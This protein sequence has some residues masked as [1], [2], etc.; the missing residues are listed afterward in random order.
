MRILPNCLCL[1][2][3]LAEGAMGEALSPSTLDKLSSWQNAENTFEIFAG[4]ASVAH[5]LSGPDG[6]PIR[7]QKVAVVV[8]GLYNSPVHM[9]ALSEYFKSQNMSVLSVRLRGHYDRDRTYL[10]QTVQWTEWQAQI[11]EVVSLAADL[12]DQLIFVGHSTGALL[13]TWMAVENPRSIVGLALFAPAFGVHPVS[14]STARLLEQLGLSLPLGRDRI[15]TAHAA[16]QVE[17]MAGIF[18]DHIWANAPRALRDVPVWIAN[19]EVDVVIRRDLAEKFLRDLT[20][21]SCARTLIQI[22][23]RE[24]ILH[25]RIVSPRSRAWSRLIDSL[26]KTIL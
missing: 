3:F 11:R 21:G 12:G 1:A 10:S 26:A 9:N 13:L 24:M 7:S 14:R 8:S 16:K 19:T 4:H 17:I 5:V 2:I 23:R 20:L 6:I 18:R 15:V 22:P 25:D